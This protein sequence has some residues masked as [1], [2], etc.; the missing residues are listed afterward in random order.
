MIEKLTDGYGFMLSCDTCSFYQEYEWGSNWHGFIEEAK[1]DG[2]R[3][4]KNK[5]SEWEH[6]CP[7]CVEKF[8]G[9]E[10]D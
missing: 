5:Y 1:R 4:K 3:L 6:Y 9:K 2:W 7:V 10:D 8:R